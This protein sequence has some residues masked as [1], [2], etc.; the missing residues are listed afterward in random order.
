MAANS[1]CLA[2][3]SLISLA[4]PF[5]YSDLAFMLVPKQERI[6][7]CG[8]AV[9]A[10]AIA[11]AGSERN[12]STLPTETSLFRRYN[13][14]P[15]QGLPSP[16]SLTMADLS[17]ILEDYGISTFPIRLDPR[18]IPAILNSH[19][20][21]ILHLTYPT[22]H[23]VLGFSY[24]D[25]QILAADPEWGLHA[26]GTDELYRRSSGAVLLTSIHNDAVAQNESV[27]R[28]LN[29]TAAK[30]DSQASLAEGRSVLKKKS[31]FEA[32]MRLSGVDPIRSNYRIDL[33]RG[34]IFWS[35]GKKSVCSLEVSAARNS[36][37]TGKGSLELSLVPGISYLFSD[38]P[39]TSTT[40]S[41][42]TIVGF[43][44]EYI[45]STNF[46]I[47][48]SRMLDPHVLSVGL[49]F[50][51]SFS[52]ERLFQKDSKPIEA[53]AEVD[54][55]IITLMNPHIAWNI[56]AR[57]SL[58]VAQTMTWKTVLEAGI[59]FLSNGA[60]L[61]LGMGATYLVDR[62]RLDGIDVELGF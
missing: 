32:S 26:M 40:A 39:E 45:L 36:L 5:S 42:F 38:S 4:R 44:P 22:R 35:L 3:L 9:L 27:E 51:P 37:H 50:A 43:A 10:G 49:S 2:I 30:L 1:L 19:G 8:Y 34:S 55:G 25:D 12:L 31:R 11:L 57:Q 21:A 18:H 20:P 52:L 41:L 24:K 56:K 54:L 59:I 53:L 60:S 14:E 33:V 6:G 13:P 29:A 58:N 48:H 16:A 61:Y 17:I 23:F 47:A 7:S 46:R 28:F 62:L 15:P